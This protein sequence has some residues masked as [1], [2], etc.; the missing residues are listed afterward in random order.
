MVAGPTPSIHLA[1]TYVRARGADGLSAPP[2]A[3]GVPGGPPVSWGRGRERWGAPRRMTSRGAE[4]NMPDRRRVP[5][6]AS[7]RG[8]H[9]RLV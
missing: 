2:R 3:I 9:A 6:P 8:R 4:Q 7:L 5:L 1:R